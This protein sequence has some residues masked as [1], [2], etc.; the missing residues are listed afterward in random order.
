MRL[1][2]RLLAVASLAQ[3]MGIAPLLAQGR[4]TPQQA[5]ITRECSLAVDRADSVERANARA[6]LDA[7][8]DGRDAFDTAHQTSLR[9]LLQRCVGLPE[10][11]G[12][13]LT[14]RIADAYSALSDTVAAEA[15]YQR[16]VAAVLVSSSDSNR[17]MSAEQFLG[18]RFA[19]R[20]STSAAIGA[21]RQ[22]LRLVPLLRDSNP[23]RIPKS[24]PEHLST[25]R[26]GRIAQRNVLFDELGLCLRQ[27]GRD[28]DAV[29][30]FRQAIDEA[31]PDVYLGSAVPGRLIET[32][33]ALNRNEEAR[34]ETVLMT[35]AQP[36]SPMERYTLA[37]AWGW[38]AKISVIMYDSA[39][40]Y[41]HALA[42][43]EQALKFDPGYFDGTYDDDRRA[44][45]EMWE[46]LTAHAL[47]RDTDSARGR[48]RASPPRNPATATAGTGFV[49]STN[50]LILT[51]QHVVAGCDDVSIR[52]AGR[53]LRAP[54]VRIVVAWPG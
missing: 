18:Q 46:S 30:E 52:V 31:G 37:R 25:D 9:L 17:A 44:E 54:G 5:A 41:A 7:L 33:L 22:A 20:D 6:K 1:N 53:A 34:R 11:L 50:G 26:E 4:P 42:A 12:N 29:R 35:G 13:W 14:Y 15:A 39:A 28:V 16:V 10:R 38:R 49:V 48:S 19:D 24:G 27:A 51:S 8:V 32:L 2:L 47:H 3:A 43:W 23:Q 36:T 45:R 21:Y 40:D